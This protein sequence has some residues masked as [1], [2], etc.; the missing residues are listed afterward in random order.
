MIDL[1][2]A[3]YSKNYRF[4]QFTLHQ[5]V[6]N[7]KWHSYPPI[8]ML[9]QGSLADQKC[10]F[11]LGITW[12]QLNDLLME[13]MDNRSRIALSASIGES[14]VSKSQDR[15][16]HLKKVLGKPLSLKGLDI[17]AKVRM[18]NGD[19]CGIPSSLYYFQLAD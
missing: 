16:I 10:E 7:P 2:K 12:D 14:L 11:L 18:F 1:G 3:L 8:F 17:S 6:I 9:C 15:E 19:S 4:H 5:L 13:A